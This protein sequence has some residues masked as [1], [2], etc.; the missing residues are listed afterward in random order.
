MNNDYNSKIYIA[1]LN[2]RAGCASDSVQLDTLQPNS[3]VV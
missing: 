1:E 2:S 3:V